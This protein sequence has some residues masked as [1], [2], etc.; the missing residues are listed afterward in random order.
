MDGEN[1]DS[2]AGDVD[3]DDYNLSDP[4]ER[5]MFFQSLFM[6]RN[7]LCIGNIARSIRR[8]LRSGR[9]NRISNSSYNVSLLFLACKNS[10]YCYFWML[11]RQSLEL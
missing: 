3:N 9:K 10:Y 11:C 8:G 5:R 2:D 1:N 4:T 6:F 7:D